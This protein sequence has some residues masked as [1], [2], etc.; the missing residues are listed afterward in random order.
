MYFWFN[1]TGRTYTEWHRQSK[2]FISQL[3]MHKFL[4]RNQI[5]L[6]H[7]FWWR[8]TLS[9]WFP[10]R[11]SFS[12]LNL[13]Q[14]LSLNKHS[15]TV[16]GVLGTC[17]LSKQR[18]ICVQ[19]VP[20]PRILF[21]E[22]FPH[23]VVCCGYWF[24]IRIKSHNCISEYSVTIRNLG[25]QL[26]KNVKAASQFVDRRDIS[27]PFSMPPQSLP[28]A[29]LHPSKHV[30]HCIHLHMDYWLSQFQSII[31]SGMR[32]IYFPHLYRW[33]RITNPTFHYFLINSEGE[34]CTK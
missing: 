21:W 3:S 5:V 24:Y 13:Q 12:V 22:T 23:T 20:V 34:F 28:A 6:F 33:G 2:E 1:N 15:S 10:A 25:C 32:M 16:N 9:L 18:C 31:N 4:S 17:L 29:M 19:L 8:E 7:C 26:S 27:S 30:L 11:D 14:F